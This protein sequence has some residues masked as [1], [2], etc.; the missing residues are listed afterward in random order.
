MVIEGI[1][2]YTQTKGQIIYGETIC[3]LENKNSGLWLKA[4]LSE[5]LTLADE[6][7]AVEL[8][9]ITLDLKVA[10]LCENHF[11]GQIKQIDS[12]LYSKNI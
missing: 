8:L 3:S 6:I 11:I 9:G 10:F 5:P 2:F 12:Y 4:K 7:H 1:T